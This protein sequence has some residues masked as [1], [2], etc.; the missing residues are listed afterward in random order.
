[1]PTLGVKHDLRE[2]FLTLSRALDPREA[3]LETENDTIRTGRAIE[4]ALA[5]AEELA[6]AFERFVVAQ[7]KQA[8]MLAKI[9]STFEVKRMA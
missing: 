7:E 4:A 9:A 6:V 3:K 5:I 8:N 1:M 2:Q